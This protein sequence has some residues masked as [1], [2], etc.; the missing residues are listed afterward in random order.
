MFVWIGFS[1][2]LYQINEYKW[3]IHWNFNLILHFS[4]QK[5][6]FFITLNKL[7]IHLLPSLTLLPLIQS[8]SPPHRPISESCQSSLV[9]CVDHSV[10]LQS[11]RAFK[12]VG[13]ISVHPLHLLGHPEASLSSHW[14]WLPYT[15]TSLKTVETEEESMFLTL[16]GILTF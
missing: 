12:S 16:T 10:S 8:F 3:N 9:P 4:S 11:T 1:L 5:H 2:S 14:E 15:H 13:C 6:F 7:C